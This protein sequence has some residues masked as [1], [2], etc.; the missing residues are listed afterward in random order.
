MVLIY[1]FTGTMTALARPMIAQRSPKS[2]TQE[3]V[4][5]MSLFSYYLYLMQ[6]IKFARMFCLFQVAKNVASKAILISMYRIPFYCYE[7]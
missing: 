6:A 3:R 2:R 5:G 7:P 1:A 4:E